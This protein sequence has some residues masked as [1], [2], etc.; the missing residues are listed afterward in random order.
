MSDATGSATG[1]LKGQRKLLLSFLGLN[2]LAGLSVG[3][4]KVVLSLFAVSLEADA[5]QLGL[6]A[7]AQSLGILLMSLP[8]GV[9]VD[10]YGPLRLFTVGT[11]I[12]GALYLTMPWVD[13]A[14]LL[15]LII[16]LISCFMPLRIVSLSAMFMQQISR[17]GVGMA[18]WFRAT[19]MG[20]MLLLGPLV[21][22]ALLETLGFSGSYITIGA[23]F[24][25]L[26]LLAPG[27]LRHYQHANEPLRTLS[28]GELKAQVALL[29]SDGL[30][31]S[32]CL[33]EFCIQA[34]HQ[35]YSFFIAVIA[36]QTFHFQLASAAALIS[37]QGTSF[38][39]A[40]LIMGGVASRVHEQ[41]FFR[42]SC[43]V[44]GGALLTLGATGSE[45]ALWLG[46]IGLGWGLGML[47][48][49]NISWFAKVGAQRGQ[50]RIAGLSTFV[51]PAGALVGSAV[52][53]T[54]GHWFGLQW[55]FV[56]MALVFVGFLLNSFNPS[57]SKNSLPD[58]Y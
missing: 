33:R 5:V 39:L 28:L 11:L 52:G 36:I 27:V 29:G 23:T 54:V 58:N 14:S 49:V 47:Q 56:L 53:G 18:G 25:L 6:I 46:G 48:I 34:V 10:Q 42:T 40:L 3:V 19:H 7:S 15:C 21:A 26:V 16:L 30:L 43:A 8:A 31:R 50:G 17:V 37:A 35:F 45:W 57:Y 41:M 13:S 32:A 20:G 9:L 22:A 1:N 55:M 12:S 24:F 51:G 2:A 4:A 44:I 38:V